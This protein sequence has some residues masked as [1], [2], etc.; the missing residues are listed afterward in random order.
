MGVGWLRTN[1]TVMP[2]SAFFLTM[3]FGPSFPELG[4]F[5]LADRPSHTALVRESP[6]GQDS[7]PFISYRRSNRLGSGHSAALPL[8]QGRQRIATF[9]EPILN[10]WT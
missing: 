2:I 1:I 3:D 8:A 5:L 10:S 9:T 4:P 7:G 6:W